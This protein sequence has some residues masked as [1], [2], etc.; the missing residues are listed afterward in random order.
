MLLFT[1]LNFVLIINNGYLN[2]LYS[3]ITVLHPR[4][5]ALVTSSGTGKYILMY[6]GKS[7]SV[8]E[9]KMSFSKYGMVMVKIHRIKYNMANIY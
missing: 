8:E 2:R 4:G 7:G 1:S 5:K 3:S 6:K 9:W